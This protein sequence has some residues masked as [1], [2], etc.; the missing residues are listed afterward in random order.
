VAAAADGTGPVRGPHRLAR[1]W[2]ANRA[3][4]TVTIAILLAVLAL[5]TSSGAFDGPVA[6]AGLPPSLGGPGGLV[7]PVASGDL[8]LRSSRS[9]RSGAGQS[10]AST[11]RSISRS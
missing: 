2:N 8:L 9:G 11:H 1:T 7:A 4:T 3:F 5:A 6:A 10:S